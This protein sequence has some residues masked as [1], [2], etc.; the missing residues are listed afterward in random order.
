MEVGQHDLVVRDHPVLSFRRLIVSFG[1]LK[2]RNSHL[3][4]DEDVIYVQLAPGTHG[5]PSGMRSPV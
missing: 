4:V 2:V 3:T 1:K 5:K